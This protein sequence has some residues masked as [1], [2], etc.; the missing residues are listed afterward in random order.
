MGQVG[1]SK[2]IRFKKDPGERPKVVDAAKVWD[3]VLPR[4]DFPLPD[5]IYMEIDMLIAEI[6]NRGNSDIDFYDCV[7]ALEKLESR[8]ILIPPGRR[9]R[10]VE[11][12]F[13][14]F[15]QNGHLFRLE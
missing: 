14:Y 4:L 11:L 8:D 6:W 5:F 3:Y 12:M 13:E 2:I 10:I 7:E 1:M 9:Q 15:E